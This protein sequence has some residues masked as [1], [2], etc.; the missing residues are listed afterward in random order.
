M[1][2]G[3]ELPPCGRALARGAG[4]QEYVEDRG[5]VNGGAWSHAADVDHIT[6]R[7]RP[8]S[9]RAVRFFWRAL[10]AV[11]DCLRTGLGGAHHSFGS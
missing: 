1:I 10:I 8:L 4:R 6:A 9:A 11:L 5:R 2:I 7:S 3:D